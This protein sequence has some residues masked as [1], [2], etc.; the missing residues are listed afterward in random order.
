MFMVLNMRSIASKVDP[1]DLT[2]RARLRDAAIL[3]FARE[4][5]GASLRAIAGDAGFSA[6]LVVHLFG[7]KERLRAECDEYVFTV[8]R[9][10]KRGVVADSAGPASFLVQMAKI[11]E[12]AP[13]VGYVVRSLQA[14]GDRARTFVEHMVADA[15]GYVAEGVAAGTIVPSR[16]EQARVRYLLGAS[17]GPLLLELSLN[18]PEDPADLGGFLTSY[19]DRVALPALELFTEGFL[20]DRRML[21]TYLL[22]IGDPP[23]DTEGRPARTPAPSTD[24]ESD[25]VDIH[26]TRDRDPRPT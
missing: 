13:L 21:D 7:S 20:T 17:L 10:T 25:D 1:G 8:V 15:A 11:E 19:F 22:Y 18:P 4:G 2:T 26:P 14:G 12:Y 6:G 3:R 16:D 24:Q 23:G 9:D 5:F